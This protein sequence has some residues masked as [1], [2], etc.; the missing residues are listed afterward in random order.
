MFRYRYLVGVVFSLAAWHS[1]RAE[2]TANTAVVEVGTTRTLIA[3]RVDG[4][5]SRSEAVEAFSNS[6]IYLTNVKGARVYVLDGLEQLSAE[7]SRG[8]PTNSNE[9]QLALQKRLKDIGPR[10]L[11]KRTQ[12]VAEGIVR[13]AQY[14]VDRVPAVVINGRSVIY[15]VSDIDVARE[16]Y[17]RE[18]SK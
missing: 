18:A 12:T 10:E 6:A 11:A 14:G 1:T 4:S 17:R 5:T 8:L 9:A 15:G 7:L 13:A 3:S 2:Q 16:L